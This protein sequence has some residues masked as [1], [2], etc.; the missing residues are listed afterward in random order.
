MYRGILRAAL[1]AGLAV[2]SVEGAAAQ[3]F[4]LEV[5]AA[6]MIRDPGVDREMFKDSDPN[7]APILTSTMM[8]IL[9]SNGVVARLRAGGEFVGVELRGIFTQ[10]GTSHW[11]DNVAPFSGI[12][13]GSADSL[14]ILGA[15]TSVDLTADR[16][17]QFRSLEA[18]FR[19]GVPLWN[20]G[21]TIGFFA[22]VRQIAVD[23]HLRLVMD[24]APAGL[25]GSTYTTDILL[26][27]SLIGPQIGV[28][29]NRRFFRIL[30]MSNFLKFGMMRNEMRGDFA[31]AGLTNAAWTDEAANRTRVVEFGMDLVLNLNQNLGIFAGA[32]MLRIA[33]IASSTQTLPNLDLGAATGEM[34][35]EQVTYAGVRAGLR[36]GF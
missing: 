2:A 36:L 32:S 8:D 20:D 31:L 34:D 25:P 19:V 21:P 7:Q 27:N 10:P 16:D 1:A 22:G 33:E 23:D 6:F 26:T 13:F 14:G 17:S 3:G 9:V 30:S 24:A 4:S 35:F 5:G 29:F 15:L 28:E 12:T 18:N 11:F